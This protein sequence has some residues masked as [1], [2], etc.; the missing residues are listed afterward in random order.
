MNLPIFLDL[1]YNPFK[2]L[3]F[4]SLQGQNFQIFLVITYD[5][6]KIFFI[7]PITRGHMFT[8]SPLGVPLPSLVAYMIN[9][10]STCD[11]FSFYVLDHPKDK[12]I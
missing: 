5:Q 11:Y 12:A 1:S 6:G 10:S 3:K 4:Y 8:W 2:K 7:L 9:M